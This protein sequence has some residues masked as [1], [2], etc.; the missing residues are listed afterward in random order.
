MRKVMR[1]AKRRETNG[2]WRENR[3]WKSSERCLQISMAFFRLKL[4]SPS[5]HVEIPLFYLHEIL[6]HWFLNS[7]IYIYVL[8]VVLIPKP[9]TVCDFFLFFFPGKSN[10]QIKK[11][12]ENEQGLD[13]M[14]LR[15]RL[16][17]EFI[18]LNICIY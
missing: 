18:K 8:C 17:N 10:Y 9:T 14:H 5:F 16:E 3:C 7:R 12:Y 6:N 1:V 11:N 13:W 15:V 2:G 4:D